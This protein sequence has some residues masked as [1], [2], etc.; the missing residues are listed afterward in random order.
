M[1]RFD[2]WN[3]PSGLATGTHVTTSTNVANHTVSQYGVAQLRGKSAKQRAA[4]LI[5]MALSDFRA[6]L[7]VQA[8]RMASPSSQHG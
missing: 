1:T 7:L 5:A 2:D 4:E 8:K 3:V 6:E